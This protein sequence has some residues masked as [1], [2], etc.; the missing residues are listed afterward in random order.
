MPTI[1]SC[2][3]RLF[4]ERTGTGDP[5]LLIHSSACRGGFWRGL[6]RDVGAGFSYYTPDL[7]GYGRSFCGYLNDKTG[8]QE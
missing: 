6:T 4:Y 2:G 5:V 7:A 1:E 3:S 8:L